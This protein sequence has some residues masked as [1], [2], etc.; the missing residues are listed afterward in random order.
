MSVC[1][2]IVLLQ[3]VKCIRHIQ[4]IHAIPLTL[5]KF[6]NSRKRISYENV[7]NV[8]QIYLQQIIQ[9]IQWRHVS[10][11][12][13]N[14][15]IRRW[16]IHSHSKINACFVCGLHGNL[17]LQAIQYCAQIRLRRIEFKPVF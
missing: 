2:A 14:F 17:C 4:V 5:A 10:L 11:A 12:K 3:M 1:N 16:K 8:S 6:T 7:G 15:A 9:V 13:S